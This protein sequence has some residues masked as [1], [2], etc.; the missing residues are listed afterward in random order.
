MPQIKVTTQ[1]LFY[2]DLMPLELYNLEKPAGIINHQI[3]IRYGNSVITDV[4]NFALDADANVIFKDFIKMLLETRFIEFNID[5]FLKFT[6][7]HLKEH[8]VANAYEKQKIRNIPFFIGELD[9]DVKGKTF[10]LK[11]F[12]KQFDAKK[13]QRHI[14]SSYNTSDDNPQF[15]ISIIG[16]YFAAAIDPE[17]LFKVS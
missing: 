17:N 15:A 5:N 2:K 9:L 14:V 16:Q 10:S 8:D 1:S 11:L 3:E 12:K 4:Y 6:E 13:P 7:F